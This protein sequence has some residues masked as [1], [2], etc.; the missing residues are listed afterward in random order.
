MSAIAYSYDRRSLERAGSMT[1][2][3]YRA[4]SRHWILVVTGG[5]EAVLML[6]AFGFGVGSLVGTIELPDG[7]ELDYVAFVAPAIL[8]TSA[9]MGVI[10]ETSINIFAKLK[11]MK[12]Y[13]GIFNTPLRPWDIALGE[14]MWAMVRGSIY[15]VMF[16][17]TMAAFGLITS[18]WAILAIPACLVVAWAFIGVGFVLA[19]LFRGWPDFD[20][21]AALVFSMFLFSGTFVPV[22]DYPAILQGVVYALPLY[23]GIEVVRGISLGML[24]P[25]LLVNVLYLLVIGFVGLYVAQ[26]RITRKMYS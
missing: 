21:M 6:L 14:A 24:S 16:V 4:M 17:L 18:W 19:T 25:W 20:W 7:R 2:R 13:D 22:E 11:W 12:V 1:Y 3:N 10:F 9:M 23:H 8:A 5:L 26:R 15:I